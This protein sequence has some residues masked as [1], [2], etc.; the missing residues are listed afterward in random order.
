MTPAR[1]EALPP[2]EPRVGFLAPDLTLTS[3]DGNSIKFSDLRGKNIIINYWVTWCAPC[4]DELPALDKISRDYQNKNLVVISVNGI[5]Q[6]QIDA[7]HEL[8]DELGLTHQIALDEDQSFWETY[9]VHFLPTSFFIDSDGIIRY[10]Q[11]GSSSEEN[12][13]D[14]V[15]RLLA[16]QL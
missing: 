14:T 11:L 10:I 15:D 7:V 8:V 1:S 13:R 6:D 3:L 16:G 5:N 4:K 12:F 2:A 9:L